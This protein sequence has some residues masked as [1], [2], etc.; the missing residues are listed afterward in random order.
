M[1]RPTPFSSRKRTTPSTAA[2]PKALPPV[3]SRACVGRTAPTGPRRSV[4]RVPGDEPLTSTPT[5]ASS[6]PSKRTAV[7]PVTPSL[8]VAWPTSTPGTSQRLSSTPALGVSTLGRFRH[9]P[10]VCVGRY[11]ARVVPGQGDE[12]AEFLIRAPRAELDEDGVSDHGVVHYLTFP[13]AELHGG[14]AEGGALL[15]LLVGVV[16]VAHAALHLTATAQDLLISRHALL[17]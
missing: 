16:L 4:S 15:E 2:S 8:R 7:Q 5:T 14:I 12:G 11:D 6:S 13:V 3:R 10:L 17:L 9:L 1:S